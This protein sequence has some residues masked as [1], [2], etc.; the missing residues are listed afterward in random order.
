M[1]ILIVSMGYPTESYRGNG[2]FEFDQAKALIEAGHK[3]VFAVIDLRSIRRWRKFGYE[4][5]VKD[6]VTIR[7]INIPVGRVP[8]SV[9][10]TIGKLAAK[11]LYKRILREL[12]R[13][14]IIHAH[15]TEPASWIVK[16][17]E[18]ESIPFVVT[19]HSSA[20]THADAQQKMKSLVDFTY[21]KADK[22][23]SVSP[24]LR[25]IIKQKFGYD[26]VYIPNV[27]DTE[28]FC[29]LPRKKNDSFR[30]ISVGALITGKRMDL[31]VTI[32]CR[33]FRNNPDASLTIIGEGVGRSEIEKIIS[34]N[35]FENRIV[36]AGMQSREF[37]A[38]AMQKSD[39]FVL[40]SRAE[41]F[42]VVYIE[43]MATGLPVIA[44]RCKGPE[45]FVNNKNGLLVPVDDEECLKNAMIY[46]YAN[47]S[48]YD[49]VAIAR[50]VAA[51]FSKSALV[52]RLEE[53]YE[54]IQDKRD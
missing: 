35:G 17:A 31:V 6:G 11:K 12:G 54:T 38:E 13:P 21:S 45:H 4:S 36:L 7:A 9:L 42:G 37:I 53:V 28:L 1:F 44:T 25:E 30:F 26:S 34:D 46:M 18:S 14:D 24:A 52:S 8:S 43:A 50:E 41:T 29:C 27:V 51:Q 47:A 39:C 15:F 48:K 33:A 22:I 19:E 32:F 10:L 49:S 3:T 23:I 16:L 5:F 20:I 40:A 2:I